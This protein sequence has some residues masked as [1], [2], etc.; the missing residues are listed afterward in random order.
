VTPI[1]LTRQMLGHLGLSEQELI[2]IRD[3]VDV[4]ADIVVRGFMV[5]H[6]KQYDELLASGRS[7]G[8]FPVLPTDGMVSDTTQQE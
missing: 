8:G 7:S 5:R 6:G 3:L 1:E 2:Q 4:Q